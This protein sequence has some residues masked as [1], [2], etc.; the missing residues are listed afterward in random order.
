MVKGYEDDTKSKAS[1]ARMPLDPIVLSVLEAWR[2]IAP[3]T[4]QDDYVFASTELE[5][6]KPTNGSS[7]QTHHLRP[8]ALRVGLPSL[9]WHALRRS[10]RTR[11]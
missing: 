3:Y 11:R 1:K 7:V 5:G 10:Y 6:K 2:K 8:A 9:G 4:R